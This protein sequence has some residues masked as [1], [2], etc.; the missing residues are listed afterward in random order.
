MTTNLFVT[1]D[2]QGPKVDITIWVCYVISGLAVTAKLLTKLGRSHR[3]IRLTNLELDD[4][5]LGASFVCKE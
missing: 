5:V 4:F 2:H 3:H 1:P